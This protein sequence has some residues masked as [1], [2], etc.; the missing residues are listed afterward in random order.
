MNISEITRRNIYDGIRYSGSSW[1]GRM[2]DVEFLSRLFDL[3][4]LPSDDRRYITA[5][6]DIWQHRINNSD[7]EDDWV[8]YDSRFNLMGCD[9]ATLLR[10][11]CE[12]IHPLVRPDTTEA[13]LLRG[14]YNGHLLFDGFQIVE[15]KRISGKPI[16]KGLYVGVA[17]AP[18]IAI[19]RDTLL[20]ADSAYVTQQIIRMEESVDSDPALA[21]GTSKELVETCCKSILCECGVTVPKNIDL[22]K[23]VKLTS[24]E[25]KLTPEDIPDEAKVAETIKHL[26]NSLATIT[27]GLAELRNRYGTGHGKESK[28]KGLESRHAK[29][30]VGASATLSTFL[31][32]TH[33]VRGL[34]NDIS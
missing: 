32:E 4:S 12:T 19:A 20:V 18:G 14:M 23:L 16:F 21:I 15:E 31:I 6:E 8:F 30:A 27:Q 11:L 34:R 24:K 7:W 1:C 29:L 28:S 10:F 17:A 22:P 33:I 9:D 26:L 5:S 2:D 13:E 25:L 3:K